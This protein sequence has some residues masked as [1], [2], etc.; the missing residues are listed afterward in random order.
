MK[1]AKAEAIAAAVFGVLA[2]L[3]LMMP[4]WIE[5]VIGV[6]PDGGSGAAEW[7]IV[8]VSG[9]LALILAASSARHLRRARAR[10]V[11][12]G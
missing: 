7:L 3:T 9:A 10:A 4:N 2:V 5:A 1:L 8:T 12:D 6:E 11:G